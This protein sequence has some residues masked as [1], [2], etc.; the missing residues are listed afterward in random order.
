VRN[1]RKSIKPAIAVG[2]IEPVANAVKGMVNM[3][4]KP[5][6]RETNIRTPPRRN[7]RNFIVHLLLRVIAPI[8]IIDSRNA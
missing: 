6:M 2:Q 7:F 4:P 8:R 1:T 3:R 5:N